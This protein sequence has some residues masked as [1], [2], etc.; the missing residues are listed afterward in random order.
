MVKKEVVDKYFELLKPELKPYG[1][2]P[3]KGD[4]SFFRKTETGFH[5]IRLLMVLY[6]NLAK[7]KVTFMF[8]IRIDAVQHLVNNPQKV[9]PSYQESTPTS[10]V[11]IEDMVKREEYDVIKN[12]EDIEESVT[13]FMVAFKSEAIEYFDTYSS[14]E[15]LLSL[16]FESH[17][18]MKKHFGMLQWIFYI[19]TIAYLYDQE[20]FPGFMKEFYPYL[21]END[22]DEA[23]VQ[24]VKSYVEEFLH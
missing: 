15:N 23:N 13:N 7:Y 5:K 4:K 22:I 12:I 18:G 2:T 24:R 6:P 1:F 20:E 9:I 10:S 16:R 21:K 11:K 3:K 8:E 19:P 14:L 17:E